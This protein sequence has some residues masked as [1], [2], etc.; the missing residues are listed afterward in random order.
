MVRKG[1]LR[2]SSS[3][4]IMLSNDH[5]FYVFPSIRS[6]KG[7]DRELTFRDRDHQIELIHVD[8]NQSLAIAFF[9][10]P[11]VSQFQIQPILL[12]KFAFMSLRSLPSGPRNSYSLGERVEKE[13]SGG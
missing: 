5:E 10:S 12:S 7:K 2:I 3:S 8:T 1:G 11:A 9:N 13:T 4:V 6:R